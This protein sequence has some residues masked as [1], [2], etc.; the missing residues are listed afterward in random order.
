M[1]VQ[2][3]GSYSARVVVQEDR[4]VVVQDMQKRSSARDMGVTVHEMGVV[5]QETGKL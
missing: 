5:V 4:G 2:E 3:K 1:T